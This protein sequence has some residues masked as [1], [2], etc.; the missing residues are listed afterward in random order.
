[1]HALVHLKEVSVVVS[2]ER[3]LDQQSSSTEVVQSSQ[4]SGPQWSTFGL[5]GLLRQRPQNQ[6]PPTPH[7]VSHWNEL[8]MNTLSQVS[9]VS[10]NVISDMHT[11]LCLLRA[12]Y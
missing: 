6:A 7:S 4:H 9:P 10:V 2:G 11:V 3:W 12:K 1:M 8:A 5:S